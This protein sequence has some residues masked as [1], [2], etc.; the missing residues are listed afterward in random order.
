METALGEFKEQAIRVVAQNTEDGIGSIETDAR[1]ATIDSFLQGP[2]VQ[3]FKE[4]LRQ[5]FQELERQNSVRKLGDGRGQIKRKETEKGEDESMG[6]QQGG[7]WMPEGT[8]DDYV[9]DQGREPHGFVPDAGNKPVLV[10][11]LPEAYGPA[12]NRV[13][14]KTDPDVDGRDHL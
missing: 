4:R 8:H 14:R 11:K 10:T 1:I 5:Q 6:V 13:Q 2:S 9:S 12:R 7:E 3:K